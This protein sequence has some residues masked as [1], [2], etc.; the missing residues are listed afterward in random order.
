MDLS[1]LKYVAVGLMALGMFGAAIGVANVFAA[2]INAIGRN[3][4]AESKLSKYAYIGAGMAEA[5]GLFALVVALLLM[6]G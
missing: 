5:M 4:E 1:S 3:P 2:L 6:F